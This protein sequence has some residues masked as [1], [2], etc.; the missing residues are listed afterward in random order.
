MVRRV[1]DM[2]EGVIE[3]GVLMNERTLIGE[4]T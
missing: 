2:E 3:G 4:K 1:G